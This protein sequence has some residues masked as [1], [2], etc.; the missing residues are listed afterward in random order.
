MLALMYT[1]WTVVR[2]T[3]LRYLLVTLIV[4]TPIVAMSNDE[5]ELSAGVAVAAMSVMMITIYLA[6]GLFG[7]DEANEWEQF[8]LTLPTSARQV[9]RSRYALAA[10]VTAGTA[11][12]GTV[13]AVI[14]QWAILA[15]HGS[16]AAPRGVVTIG[17]TALGA[18]IVALAF[19]SI[20]MPIVFRLGISKARMAFTLPFLL[21]MLLTIGPVRDA[22]MPILDGIEALANSLGTPAPLF[23]GAAAVVALLYLASMRLSEGIYA[24]R[25]F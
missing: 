5:G 18:G 16:I 20:E 9:V 4:M 17:L 24:A 23:A 7:V 13:L 19:L 11:V 22:I 12:V 2:R 1:D 6:L 14:A 8:R 15:A 25:D 10:L 3:F 21:C